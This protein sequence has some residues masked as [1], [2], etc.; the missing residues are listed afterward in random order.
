MALHAILVG[1]FLVMAQRLFLTVRTI[2]NTWDSSPASDLLGHFSGNVY[3][4]A[5][6]TTANNLVQEYRQSYCQTLI[7][8]RALDDWKTVIQMMGGYN[9]KSHLTLLVHRF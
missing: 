1:W 3:T 2:F 4:Q 7:C 9:S 6:T 5:D 8:F